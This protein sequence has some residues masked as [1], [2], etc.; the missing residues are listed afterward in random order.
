MSQTKT[1]EVPDIGDFKDVEI[2]E[3]LVQPGSE[4]APEDPLITLESDKAT[5]DVPAP[6]A[7]TVKKMHVKVGDKVSK[8]SKLLDL[9]ASGD[10]AGG[11]DA[12][13][14][15]KSGGEGK[16]FGSIGPADIADALTAKGTEVEKKEVRMPEGPLRTT[17]EFEVGLHLHSDV[18]IEIHVVVVG[19]E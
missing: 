13:I 3:V 1:I 12:E 2:I 14:T 15:A 16:L 6:E 17:G 9:E 18:D 7:G 11:E 4:I 19:E 8:G 10:A 5:I